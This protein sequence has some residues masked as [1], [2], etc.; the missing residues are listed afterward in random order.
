MTREEFI[1]NVSDMWE[2]RNFCDENNMY[3]CLD[4]YYDRDQA[5]DYICDLIRD[6]VNHVS[7]EDIKDMLDNIPSGY[8]WYKDDD[9][10]I[11]APLTDDDFEY[12]RNDILE[13]LDNMDFFDA[14]EVDDDDEEFLSSLNEDQKEVCEPDSSSATICFDDFLSSNEKILQ[15]VQEYK[16]SQTLPEEDISEEISY[17]RDFV[18]AF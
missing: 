7:W 15:T 4:G 10:D 14:E 13:Q 8:D 6:K 16:L 1:E 17:Q 2:L 18:F 11:L 5:D 3:E 12:L 9:Y